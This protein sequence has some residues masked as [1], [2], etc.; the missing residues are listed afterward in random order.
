MSTLQFLFTAASVKGGTVRPGPQLDLLSDISCVSNEDFVLLYCS[1]SALTGRRRRGPVAESTFVYRSTTPQIELLLFH[2]TKNVSNMM[3]NVRP[4]QSLVLL[5][6][7]ATFLVAMIVQR[8]H[9]IF[10]RRRKQ[11][12]L[13]R[14]DFDS[15]CRPTVGY[16]S[17]L[18]RPVGDTRQLPRKMYG[19]S[20]CSEEVMRVTVAAK[21]PFTSASVLSIH[22]SKRCRLTVSS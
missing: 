14:L 10:R 8:F 1:P 18:P 7:I 15:S 9:D 2:V 5:A 21:L 3:A 11:K 20:F 4:H 22:H 16:S 6:N 13:S 17:V 19:H 12:V